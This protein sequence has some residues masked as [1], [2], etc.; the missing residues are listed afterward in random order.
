MRCAA[1]LKLNCLLVWAYTPTRRKFEVCLLHRNSLPKYVSPHART[2]LNHL[3]SCKWAQL[4]PIPDTISTVPIMVMKIVF[5]FISCA[6][7]LLV[8]C[9]VLSSPELSKCA[10][11]QLESHLIWCVLYWL[12]YI[13]HWFHSYFKSSQCKCAIYSL[14]KMRMSGANRE[15]TNTLVDVIHQFTMS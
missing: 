15:E 9:T 3:P 14:R 6:V 10:A 1:G 11:W 2:R 7:R 8:D 4:A 13:R 12:Q 5:R